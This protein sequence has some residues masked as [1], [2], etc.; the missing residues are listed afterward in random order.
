[1]KKW[2][3]LVFVF[4]IL[5]VAIFAVAGFLNKEPIQKLQGGIIIVTSTYSGNTSLYSLPS[6]PAPSGK[7]AKSNDSG[8]SIAD[9]IITSSPRCWQ[10]PYGGIIMNIRIENITNEMVQDMTNCTNLNEVVLIECPTTVIQ[11]NQTNETVNTDCVSGNCNINETVNNTSVNNVSLSPAENNSV[12]PDEV[13]EQEIAEDEKNINTEVSEDEPEVNFYYR[14]NY[15]HSK[16]VR[17]VDKDGMGI[18]DC[19]P[20]NP[21]ED[22]SWNSEEKPKFSPA[23][24]SI[25]EQLIKRMFGLP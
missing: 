11:T 3:Y 12:I 2:R 19:N 5:A 20:K 9:Q 22:L 23:T 7:E 6:S 18:S 24:D 13:M 25:L 16:C 17:L 21:E 4:I 15:D 14:W 8:N 10:C 1:M